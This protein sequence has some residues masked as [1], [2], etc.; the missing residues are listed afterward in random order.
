MT[1]DFVGKYVCY[2]ALDGGACWGR[3]K[4]CVVINTQNGEKDAFILEDRWVRYARGASR[5]RYRLFHDDDRFDSKVQFVVEK[6]N[7]DSILRCDQIDLD[8][9][10]VSIGEFLSA[11]DTET[12]FLAFMAGQ[13]QGV[14]GSKALEIGIRV[15]LE[16]GEECIVSELKTRLDLKEE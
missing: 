8:K 13:G 10:V 12:L 2:D 15:L 5:K 11:I 9:D 4:D 14:D 7:G 6:N 16:S 1:C 3:I